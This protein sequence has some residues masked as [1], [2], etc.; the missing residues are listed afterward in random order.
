MSKETIKN[1]AKPKKVLHLD[2]PKEPSPR[3]LLKFP[4]EPRG[5]DLFLRNS[6]R[7]LRNFKTVCS[8]GSFGV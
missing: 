4:T 8:E 3:N 7:F 6:F 1:A 2:T 5:L